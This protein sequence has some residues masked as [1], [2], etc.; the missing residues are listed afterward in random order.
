MTWWTIKKSNIDTFVGIPVNKQFM[1]YTQEN[2]VYTAINICPKF[3][4]LIYFWSNKRS[5]HQQ[6]QH[7]FD[8]NFSSCCSFTIDFFGEHRFDNSYQMKWD[9]H[10]ETVNFCNWL[11]LNMGTISVTNK[12]QTLWNMTTMQFG[13]KGSLFFFCV[14]PPRNMSC[15]W[16]T[17]ST[18]NKIH[19]RSSFIY[20]PFSYI[21]LFS[22]LKDSNKEMDRL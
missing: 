21:N 10:A 12:N 11:C 5:I 15:T 6:G 17:S 20:K 1:K 4:Q 7:I 3:W 19:F 2:N 22:S 8:W 13:K 18:P 16:H 14:H 9:V